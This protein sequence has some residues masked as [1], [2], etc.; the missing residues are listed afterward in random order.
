MTVPIYDLLNRKRRGE[1]LTTSDLSRLVDGFADRTIPDYQL[2]AFLM[3][4]AIRGLD[5]RE[6]ADLTRLMTESGERW[7]LR[8]RF[9]FIADKHS[10][11]GVG[12]KVSL[13]LAP[14][15]AA[16]GVK[17]GM[18]S[19]RGLGHTGGTLDKLESIPGFN[20]RMTREEFERCID[21]I[22]CAITTSTDGI[23]RA[24]RTMYALRDVTGTVE[25]IPLITASI[26]SKKLAMGATALILDVKMGQGAFCKDLETARALSRGLMAAARGSGTQ[27]EVLITDMNRPLGIAAGNANEVAEAFQALRGK[28]PADLMEVTRAQAVR[29]LVMSGQY[30]ESAAGPTLDQTLQSGEALSKARQWIAAQGGEARFIDDPSVL[31]RPD[32][33]IEVRAPR[34]GSIRS[35]D[36]YGAGML[37]VQLGAGRLKHDDE[38]DPAAGIMFDRNVG[39]EVRAGEVIARI[40]AGRRISTDDLEDQYLALVDIGEKP[41]K[42]RPLILELLT[43]A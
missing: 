37:A 6:L 11:G 22:G 42:R 33:V 30:D 21:E 31:A 35:I 27:A 41:S 39:D 19:G 26:M 8:N 32:K 25:S 40:Q 14:W 23:A 4:V 36:T 13:V 7:H 34:S 3:A 17:I 15:V 28:G 43:D 16:C 10:T 24:D 20:A 5:P 18:L 2:S 29:V 12:D 9:D 1:S 38:L